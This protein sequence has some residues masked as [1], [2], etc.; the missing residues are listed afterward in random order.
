[1]NLPDARTWFKFR[2]KTTNNIQGNTTSNFRKNMQCR[3]CNSGEDETQEYL[4]KY[5][6]TKVMRRT[7]N[8]ENEGGN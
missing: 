1:M 2:C 4:E 5:E 8:L 3:H 7:L 6:F